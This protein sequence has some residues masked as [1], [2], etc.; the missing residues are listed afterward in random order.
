MDAARPVRV[1]DREREPVVDVL[2]RNAAEGRLGP[3]ELEDRLDATYRARM[4]ADLV[5]LTRDL[6]ALPL[7]AADPDIRL[8]AGWRP[9][10]LR[11]AIVNPAV[12]AI[13]LAAGDGRGDFWPKWV[14]IVSTIALVR[15]RCRRR[16]SSPFACLASSRVFPSSPAASETCVLTGSGCRRP[17]S[18]QRSR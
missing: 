16:A 3:E 2:R 6:P 13:W 15:S 12:I 14:L 9:A 11:W 10:G 17:R 18:A 1:G 4:D 7:E 8:P 5:P